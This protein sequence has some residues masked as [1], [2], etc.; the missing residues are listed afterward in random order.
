MRKTCILLVAGANKLFENV[1]LWIRS[2]LFA[3]QGFLSFGFSKKQGF[4]PK[5]AGITK[6]RE[7]ET[8]P[9]TVRVFSLLFK[10]V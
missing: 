2:I 10:E 6:S 4:L 9:I 3:G 1:A 8:L 5:T 7:S